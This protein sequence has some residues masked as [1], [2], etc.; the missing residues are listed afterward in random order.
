MG[1]KAGDSYREDGG[2]DGISFPGKMETVPAVM[3]YETGIWQIFMK[4]QPMQVK[5]GSGKEH[6]KKTGS[7]EDG[8]RRSQRLLLTWLIEEDPHYLTR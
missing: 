3:W 6:K 2:L 1:L 8:I 7:R 4:G 5:S